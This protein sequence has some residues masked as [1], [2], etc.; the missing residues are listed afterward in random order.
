M[1]H[2]QKLDAYPLSPGCDYFTRSTRTPCI[3]T[4]VDIDQFTPMGDRI[5]VSEDT[6]GEWAR[7]LGWISPRDAEALK[8]EALDA[9][10]RAED[11]EYDLRA[12]QHVIR[13]LESSGFTIPEPEQVPITQ[14]P[15]H[16]GGGW[17]LFSDGTTQ[18]CSAEEA[19]NVERSISEAV[20]T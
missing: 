5:Y 8:R 19:A 9:Q 6:V 17:W 11:A 13:A 10:G 14:F 4:G 1:A 18:R 2:N 16:K 7:M 15:H 3:D 20:Y 12:L